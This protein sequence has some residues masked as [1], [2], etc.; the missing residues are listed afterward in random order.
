MNLRIPRNYADLRESSDIDPRPKTATGKW[1]AGKMRAKTSRSAA[2]SVTS[3][4]GRHLA[5]FESKFQHDDFEHNAQFMGPRA[6]AVA[7]SAEHS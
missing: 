6:A 1:D 3:G 7:Q 2:L 4:E 5:A